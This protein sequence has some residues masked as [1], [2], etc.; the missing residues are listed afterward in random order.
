MGKPINIQGSTN[1]LSQKDLSSTYEEEHARLWDFILRRVPE[2]EDAEDLMQDVFYQLSYTGLDSIEQVS[3]WLFTVAR[4]KITDFYRK[5]RPRAF[6]KDASYRDD[7]DDEAVDVS[8][9]LPDLSQTPELL[10]AR[11]L[12]Q[13][14]FEE[15]LDE[16]PEEQRL[17][18]VEHEL[19][20]KSF[21]EISADTG[22]SVNTLLSRKRYAVLHLRK[23]LK[24]LYDEL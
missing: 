23:R 21:K 22:V 15:A 18:F 13:R 12:L 19:A 20:H 4:N 10:F 24:E 16:L 17:V 2:W 7:E 1:D 14:A 5:K 8:Q 6:S 3:A 11:S 9:L